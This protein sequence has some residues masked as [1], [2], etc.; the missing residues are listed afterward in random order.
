MSFKS[1]L[2][3]RSKLKILSLHN[4]RCFYCESPLTMEQMHLDHYIPYSLI[5]SY[6]TKDFFPSCE[7]CNRIKRD[8]V[9]PTITDSI[10]FVNQRRKELNLPYLSKFISSESTVAVILL[11]PLSHDNVVEEEQTTY[12]QDTSKRIGR[13]QELLTERFG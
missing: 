5:K 12:N 2:T 8:Y 13:V 7:A 10:Q 3:L 9:F 4:F 11:S 6:K 1:K